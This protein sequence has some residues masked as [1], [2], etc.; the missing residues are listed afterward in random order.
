[1]KDTIERDLK[2]FAKR[3]N[4]SPYLSTG[5]KALIIEYT[6]HF[7]A[8]IASEVTAGKREVLESIKKELEANTHFQ[9]IHPEIDLG[10]FEYV[11]IENLRYI[12]DSKLESL[13]ESEGE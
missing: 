7:S 4:S 13:K 9:E 10:I 11:S 1:M 6:D 3:L 8:L 2:E 12:F 5:A